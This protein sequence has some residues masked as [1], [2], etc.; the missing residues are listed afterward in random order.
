[1][2][3]SGIIV[4]I[5]LLTADLVVNN[6]RSS[7]TL[8]S[9]QTVA[10]NL[11]QEIVFLRRVHIYCERSG[12]VLLLFTGYTT[13]LPKSNRPLTTLSHNWEPYIQRVP[14]LMTNILPCQ[15]V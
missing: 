3:R 13:P 1:M 9:I 8:R 2:K 15:A 12:L 6:Y 7:R 4:T 11:V 10:I 14:Q 5:R